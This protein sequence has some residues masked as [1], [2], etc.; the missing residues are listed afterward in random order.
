MFK[1][2]MAVNLF[3]VGVLAGS[4]AVSS[5]PAIRADRNYNCNRMYRGK[6]FILRL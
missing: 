3:F 1:I 5:V 2:K 6:H 4:M